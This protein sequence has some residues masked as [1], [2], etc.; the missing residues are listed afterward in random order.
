LEQQI[1]SVRLVAE[2]E[3]DTTVVE[4]EFP[5]VRVERAEPCAAAPNPGELVVDDFAWR[6]SFDV[7]GFDEAV[8]RARPIGIVSIRGDDAAGVACEVLARYQRLVG[9]RNVAS[10]TPLF[11]RVLQVHAAAYD[12]KLPEVEAELDH[13][14]DTWQWMLRLEPN[15]GLAAQLAAIFHDIDRLDSEP[16][17]RIEHRVLDPV[18][19]TKGGARAYAMLCDA[20]VPEAVAARARKIMCTLEDRGEDPD[21]VLL[22]DADALSFLSLNSSRYADH[23]GLAQTR[24]KVAFTVGRLGPRARAKLALVR[25]RPDVERLLRDSAA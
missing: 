13:A 11:D 23:F 22:D 2:E 21:A 25:S 10:G 14:L 3:L 5:T 7:G 19:L 16:H 17:E 15:A 6:G 8:E 20:G 9:R 18:R 12:L 24:R 4:R 1:L